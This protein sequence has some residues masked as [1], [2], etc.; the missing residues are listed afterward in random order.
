MPGV[1]VDSGVGEG[2]EVPLHYD[3]LL[4]KVIATSAT[5]ED[6]IR[7]LAGALR[8]FP[9]LGVHTNIE[10]LLQIL[11]HPRFRSGD[12]DT[13]W[14][15]A[16]GASLAAA[17]SRDVPAH[18]RAAVDAYESDTEPAGPTDAAQPDPWQSLREWRA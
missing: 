15:D 5:R 1:R 2:T 12:I 6:A 9:I 18:V 16:D 14:L 17:G 4:A 10:F 11:D 7:R 3:P 8:E 13:A